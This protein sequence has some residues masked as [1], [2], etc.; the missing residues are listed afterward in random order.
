VIITNR[1]N[2]WSIPAADTRLRDLRVAAPMP[3][4]V[5]MADQRHVSANSSVYIY[6]NSIGST[7]ICPTPFNVGSAGTAKQAAPPRGLRC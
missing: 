3:N 4:G 7:G 5:E 1:S 6:D 2:G